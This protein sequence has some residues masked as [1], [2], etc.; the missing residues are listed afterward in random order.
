METKQGLYQPTAHFFLFLTSQLKVQVRRPKDSPHH[1]AN[2]VVYGIQMSHFE[3]PKHPFLW[4]KQ[5]EEM[6]LNLIVQKMGLSMDFLAEW[7]EMLLS[8]L[9]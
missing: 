5:R 2:S 8:C 4:D 9:C 7:V 6:P 3:C 1:N